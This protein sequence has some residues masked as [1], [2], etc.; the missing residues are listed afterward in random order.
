L[1]AGSSKAIFAATVSSA[2]ATPD[3]TIIFTS[4]GISKGTCTLAKGACSISISTATYAAATYSVIAVY[5]G[6]ATY[7]SSASTAAKLVVSKAATTV[8]PS[9]TSSVEAGGTVT[10]VANVGR[11][12]GYTGVPTGT[13]HFYS[14]T[15][16]QSTQGVAELDGTGKA[17]YEQELTGVPAGT[18]SV[19]AKYAGDDSD[20]ASNSSSLTVIVTKALTEVTLTSSANP[21]TEGSP[22]SITAVV[23]HACCSTVPPS[24]TVAFLLGTKSLGTLTLTSGSAVLPVST[25]GLTPGTYS[26]VAK[27]S[28][29]ATNQPS[30]RTF[31]LTV[32]APAAS[33][34]SAATR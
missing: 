21:V 27:Y 20:A 1:A 31:S 28:G 8:T 23:T 2:A 9:G 22:V 18:Y 10:L 17:V 6:S 33:S 4:N 29:D 19:I 26:V 14:S 32:A 7:E 24:G 34:A 11:P 30:T 25:T 16:L 5:S 12:A 3:G 13:V 15:L